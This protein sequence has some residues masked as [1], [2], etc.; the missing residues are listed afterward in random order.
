M[1][2]ARQNL[3]REQYRTSHAGWQTSGERYEQAVR[4]VLP[5]NGWLLDVGCGR[6]GLPEK[7]STEGQSHLIGVDPDFQSLTE[8]RAP[9]VALASAFANH[10][11]FANAQFDVVIATWVFEHLDSPLVT[12]REIRRI[13]RPNGA[14]VFIT[15]NRQHPL[16][17]FNR[18]SQWFPRVQAQ[19]VAKLYAR[20]AEDTFPVHYR[21]N[22]AAQLANLCQQAGFA[23][24]SCQAIHDPTYLA[25]HPL[26]FRLSCWLENL[27]PQGTGIHLVGTCLCAKP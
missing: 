4:T 2:L 24:F 10:L 3:Y 19:L 9:A 11:P 21:A 7:L 14:L 23:H 6:G 13:L 17:Q 15:P 18:I 8:Y 22:Q 26:L 27:L 5:R 20:A 16:V 1:D 12:L 25:F